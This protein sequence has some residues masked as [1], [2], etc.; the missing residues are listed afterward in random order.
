[1][2]TWTRCCSERSIMQAMATAGEVSEDDGLVRASV[3]GDQ[4]A[5]AELYVR[6]ARMVH[7]VLLARVPP[8]Q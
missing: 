4:A 1:M 8:K 2:R 7:G 6:Y 5:F 3:A